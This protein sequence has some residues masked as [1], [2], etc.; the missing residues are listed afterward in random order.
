MS[1]EK[2]VRP[3]SMIL[4]LTG[5]YEGYMGIVE[6]VDRRKDIWVKINNGPDRGRKTLVTKGN[7]KMVTV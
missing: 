6:R 7:Y 5:P 3:G 4:I 2:D 1:R